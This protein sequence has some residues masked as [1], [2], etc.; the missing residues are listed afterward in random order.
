MKSRDLGEHEEQ[1]LQS[2]IEVLTQVG[3]VEEELPSDEWVMENGPPK[4]CVIFVVPKKGTPPDDKRM[5]EDFRNTN[6]HV[7]KFFN[8][9]LDIKAAHKRLV[10][11]QFYAVLDA[12]KG[13][14][15]FPVT[16]ELSYHL[17]FVTNKG[18]MHRMKALQVG[19]VNS[20]QWYSFVMNREVLKNLVHECCLAYIDDILVYAKS[21]RDL[22]NRLGLVLEACREKNVQLN[23][24][25]PNCLLPLWNGAVGRYRMAEYD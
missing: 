16:T 2:H 21:G 3:V 24:K 19:F 13:Y 5:I 7:K 18:K 25:S 1:W 10:G 22:L 23:I 8:P 15:Q 9:L 17:V 20:A 11:T 6:D 12:L 14:N 4:C